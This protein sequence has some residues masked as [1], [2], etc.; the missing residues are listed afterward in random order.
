MCL[1]VASA[2][3][4]LALLLKRLCRDEYTS[5]TIIYNRQCGASYHYPGLMADVGAGVEH[6]E[7]ELPI[8]MWY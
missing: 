4:G 8:N 6:N 2:V 7:P 3:D 1:F 5:D